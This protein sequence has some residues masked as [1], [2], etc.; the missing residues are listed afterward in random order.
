MADLPSA[1]RQAYL[2]LDD[3]DSMVTKFLRYYRQVYG[4]GTLQASL[5]EV[6]SR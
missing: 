2:S 5:I 3:P 4:K 6:G 1:N